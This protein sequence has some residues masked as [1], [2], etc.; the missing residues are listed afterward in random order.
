MTHQLTITVDDNVYQVLKPMVEQKTIGSFLYDF[1][2]NRQK[3]GKAPSIAALRGTL[4]RV[5]TSDL[6]DET[7]RQL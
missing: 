6:R 4:H 5:D 2:K 7:E 1:M 3:K